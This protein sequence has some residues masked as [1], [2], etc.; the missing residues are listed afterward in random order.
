MKP[1]TTSASNTS[2][3]WY[4]I[5]FVDK[6]LLSLMNVC[7]TTSHLSSLIHTMGLAITLTTSCLQISSRINAKPER[8]YSFFW[9]FSD[10]EV[11]RHNKHCS[12]PFSIWYGWESAPAYRASHCQLQVTN[13]THI[14]SFDSTPRHFIRYE[15]DSDVKMM[16]SSAHGVDLLS[17]WHTVD[18]DGSIEV[19]D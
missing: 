15:D 3:F 10:K 4:I 17:F 14:Y 2:I 9:D 12:L 19:R 13:I 16:N 18:V 5:S 8:R 1:H 11:A 7:Y 6:L